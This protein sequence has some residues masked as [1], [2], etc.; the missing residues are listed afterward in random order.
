MEIYL[1]NA[2]TTRPFPEVI[3]AML[4]YLTDEY[5]NPSTIYAVGRRA[6]KAL[7]EARDKIA[8][9]L[10][11][12]SKEII[13]CSGATESIC[14][15]LIGAA[16]GT[17]DDKKRFVTSEIEHHAV[18]E[19]GHW[20]EKHLGWEV[21]LI[22]PKPGGHIDAGVFI[23]ACTKGC[24][25][26]SLQW[27]NNEIGTIQPIEEVAS[28]LKGTPTVFHTDIVQG[29]GKM[30]LDLDGSGIDL[31]SASGHK[32]Y[33]PKGIGITY[34][35][36]GPAKIYP[37]MTGG[38]QELERRAGTENVAGYVGLAKALEILA[39]GRD[40]LAEKLE[41]LMSRFIEVLDRAGVEYEINAT[42]PKVHGMVNFYF[43]GVESESLLL[44]ADRAGVC[45]SAGSACSSGSVQPSYVVSAMGHEK[46]RGLCSARISLGW[47]NTVG[48]VEEGA[49]RIAE[50]VTKLRG[51]T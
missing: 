37:V 11:V 4:P 35:R 46:M 30:H 43:P 49:K 31:A 1:D 18:L 12:L 41:G 38:G 8:E 15:S 24:G 7:D 45:I 9:I 32:F 21:T 6:R 16:L 20:L 13:F 33:T 42:E 51:S 10:G 36:E 40:T 27:V 22:S 28:G 14:T 39:S 23:E 44:H 26:A 50:I 5:G 17:P 34:V 29:I 25:L 48:D 3:D 19:T 47:H 2:A